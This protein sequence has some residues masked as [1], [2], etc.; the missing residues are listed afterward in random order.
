MT[1]RT[2]ALYLRVSTGERT[3]ENQ[4]ASCWSQQRGA[5][6]YLRQRSARG[7][8]RSFAAVHRGDSLNLTHA[9]R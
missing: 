4:A 5:A 7:G 9:T 3:V 1:Q 6:W 2:V 8:K